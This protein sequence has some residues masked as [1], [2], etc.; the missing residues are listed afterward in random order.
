[1]PVLLNVPLALTLTG[2]AVSALAQA[3]SPAGE[4]TTPAQEWR[5]QYH[6]QPEPGAEGVMDAHRWERLW[7]SLDQQAP[8]LDFTRYCAVVAYAGQRPTGGFTLEFF[9]P[10]P[11]GDDFLIRWRIR[12]PAP[13]S[14]T[15]QAQAQPWKVRAFPR[16]RGKV[17]LEQVKD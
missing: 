16:P 8:A 15:T 14:Y 1:M 13:D 12:S 17:K 10:V 3:P 5:G 7:R 11:Q 6:G 2:T 9:E 4:R